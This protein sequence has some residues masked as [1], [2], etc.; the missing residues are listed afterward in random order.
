MLK[1][2]MPWLDSQPLVERYAWFMATDGMLTSG[3]GVSEL[4]KVYMNYTAVSTF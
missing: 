1:T 2:V 4:G 3:G